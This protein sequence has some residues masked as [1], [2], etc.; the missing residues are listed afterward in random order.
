MMAHDPL[1]IGY[2]L[3][4]GGLAAAVITGSVVQAVTAERPECRHWAK[5]DRCYPED[6]RG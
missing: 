4:F 6:P 5:D 3:V 1:F 2:C